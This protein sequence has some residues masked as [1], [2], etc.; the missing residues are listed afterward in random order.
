MHLSI[1]NCKYH[2]IPPSENYWVLVCVYL[3][4]PIG[5]FKSIFDFCQ[6]ATLSSLTI[7]WHLRPWAW[8]VFGQ[9][10]ECWWERLKG[11]TWRLNHLAKKTKTDPYLN[12]TLNLS[13]INSEIKY[14]FGR[15][16]CPC[17]LLSSVGSQA[18][19]PTLDWCSYGQI[20]AILK[21]RGGPQP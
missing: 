16:A 11:H 7:R 17:R 8:P 13:L 15:Q 2:S 5:H 3:S 1:L 9:S 18:N 14:R 20:G 12:Q 6:S 4:R 19:H 21:P 10:K